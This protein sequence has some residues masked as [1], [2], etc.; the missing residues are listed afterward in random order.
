VHVACAS[1]R[2]AGYASRRRGWKSSIAE[3]RR[4]SSRGE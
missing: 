4:G 1:Y 3:T 2:C